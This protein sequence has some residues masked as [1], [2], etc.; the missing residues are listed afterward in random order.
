MLVRTSHVGSGYGIEGEK[1][2]KTEEEEVHGGIC[3]EDSEEETGR[4]IRRGRVEET[5]G[6]F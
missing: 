5:K 4:V 2:G 6:R 3:M 1:K